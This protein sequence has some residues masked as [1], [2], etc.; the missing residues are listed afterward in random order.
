MLNPLPLSRFFFI[1]IPLISNYNVT[2]FGRR[3]HFASVFVISINQPFTAL[4]L[5]RNL[6]LPRNS[7]DLSKFFILF[8]NVLKKDTTKI[9]TPNFSF[10]H[11]HLC[12]EIRR[13]YFYIYVFF[14]FIVNVSCS[15]LNN[16]KF[17]SVFYPSFFFT[18]SEC[19]FHLRR[20]LF[21]SSRHNKA[22]S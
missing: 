4:T 1:S 5:A 19:F 18:I 12:P 22:N 8:F 11:S 16:L 7:A 2:V 21:F 3:E 15:G 9:S 6:F 10:N 13:Q 20:F 14:Y 17:F